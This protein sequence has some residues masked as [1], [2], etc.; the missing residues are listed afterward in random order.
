[1]RME[2]AKGDFAGIAIFINQHWHFAQHNSFSYPNWCCVEGTAGDAQQQESSNRSLTFRA[3]VNTR[4]II[5]L[6]HLA[7]NSCVLNSLLLKICQVCLIYL[8][9]ILIWLLICLNFGSIMHIYTCAPF[10]C[11]KWISCQIHAKVYAHTFIHH[12]NAIS[13]ILSLVPPCSLPRTPLIFYRL[14]LSL[15]RTPTPSICIFICIYKA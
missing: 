5:M 11:I 9:A 13:L 6:W 4:T 15:S 10:L 1:M 8:L 7:F 3:Q 2:W 14:T 12:Q